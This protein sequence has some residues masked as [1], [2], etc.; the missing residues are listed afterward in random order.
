MNQHLLI[1]FIKEH[2]WLVI[3]VF[4]ASFLRLYHLSSTPISLNHDETAIGYNAYALLKTGADEHGSF[5]PLSLKSFGDWKL[6]FYPVVTIVSVLFFGLSEFAVRLPS[7]LAGI[8]G[9]VLTY[10]ISQEL[11]KQKRLSLM[12]A[13]LYALSPWGIYFSR[14][15]Y[16]TNLALSI[17]LLGLYLFL[18]FLKKRLGKYLIVTAFLFGITLFTYHAYVLFMPLFVISLIALYRKHFAVSSTSITAATIFLLFVLGSVISTQQGSLQKVSSVSIINDK[19]VIY[20]RAEKFRGDKAQKNP[21]VERILHTKFSA[22]PYQ[23]TQNYVAAFSPAFLFDKGGEKL[24]HT[25]GEF[26][27][28]YLLDGLLLIIGVAAFFWKREPAWKVLAIWLFIGMIPSAIT[29]D[30]PSST[31]LFIILTVLLIFAGYGAFTLLKFVRGKNIFK[32]FIVA[33]IGILY[34]INVIYF[35]DIYFTHMN[36]HRAIFLHYG[37]KQVVELTKRYPQYTVV[38]KGPENFP[39]VSFLFYEKYD[40]ILFRKEVLYYPPTAEGFIF[41][42]QFGKYRFVDKIDYTNLKEKTIY[43][44]NPNLTHG[45]HVIML[46]NNEPIFGYTVVN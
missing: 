6:P 30:A 45:A 23:I 37:Y 40:P 20:Q 3:I 7:A 1:R 25:T 15:A 24:L 14:I 27:N 46:P 21:F 16:E 13:L 38:M 26:G 17:F 5:L 19:N 11:F 18:L 22:V 28:L 10:L 32:E 12:I 9:I 4:L 31:R 39:Y 35:L 41:V 2:K 34:L 29:R 8:V 42:K 36:T 44:D 33:G 43:I